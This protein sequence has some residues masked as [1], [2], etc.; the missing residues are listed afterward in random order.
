MLDFSQLIAPTVW[1]APRTTSRECDQA[2]ADEA[3][4]EGMSGHGGVPGGSWRCR[5]PPEAKIPLC[6]KEAGV[7]KCCAGAAGAYCRPGKEYGVRLPTYR[8]QTP[9]ITLRAAGDP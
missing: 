9:R 1:G 5:A 2:Q 6:G 3:F 7:G 4:P 8:C